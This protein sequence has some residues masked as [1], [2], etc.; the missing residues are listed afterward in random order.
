MQSEVVLVLGR[1]VGSRYDDE[2]VYALKHGFRNADLIFLGLFR[3]LCAGR[4]LLEHLAVELNVLAEMYLGGLGDACV[5]QDD[6]RPAGSFEKLEIKNRR[7]GVGVSG[8]RHGDRLFAQYQIFG[9]RR[10]QRSSG[11][12][13]YSFGRRRGGCRRSVSSG[14]IMGMG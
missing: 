1:A 13:G 5:N 14:L 11:W 9:Q 2:A 12:S 6:A 3:V 8:G 4:K 7:R 10:Y